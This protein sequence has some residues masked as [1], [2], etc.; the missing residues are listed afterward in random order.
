MEIVVFRLLLFVFI[1]FPGI[2]NNTFFVFSHFVFVL[3]ISNPYDSAVLL[4][5]D[6]ISRC[7][8]YSA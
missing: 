3:L 5:A 2:S 6:F 7:W 1:C 8:T 4:V